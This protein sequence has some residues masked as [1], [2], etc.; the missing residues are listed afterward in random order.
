MTIEISTDIERLDFDL[1]HRFLSE[2]SYWA[3][4]RSMEMVRKAIENSLNFGVYLDGQQIGFARVVT[5][6]TTFA[7]LADVFIVTGHRGH[8]YSK[9][10]VRSIM[11][12]PELQGL[13]RWFLATRDAHGLYARFG[14]T[15][16]PPDR[17][18]ERLVEGPPQGPA[19]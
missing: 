16:V 18:M 12:H 3:R 7:W 9:M 17:F 8:G 15:A 5:D 13:R 10:L 11:E 19:R 4:G 2:E 14:F 6:R 1:I